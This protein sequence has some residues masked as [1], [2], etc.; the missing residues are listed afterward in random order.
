MNTL[1]PREK[2]EALDAELRRNDLHPSIRSAFIIE[3]NK[4]TTP[5]PAPRTGRAT[6]GPGDRVAYSPRWTADHHP[7]LVV[8]MDP[9]T[10]IRY[11]N[12]EVAED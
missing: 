12:Y 8:G 4:L 5:E 10:G 11:A 7:W 9:A 1:T 2:V 3:R 6:W